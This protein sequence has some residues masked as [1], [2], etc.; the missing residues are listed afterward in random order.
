VEKR[1]AETIAKRLEASGITVDPKKIE[2]GI[3]T[4]VQR[5]V[6]L[7]HGYFYAMKGEVNAEL[8]LDESEMFDV[9]KITWNEMFEEPK[10]IEQIPLDNL[11]VSAPE[12]LIEPE[13]PAPPVYHSGYFA[14][15]VLSSQNHEISSAGSTGATGFAF[16][17]G[18]KDKEKN[19]FYYEHEWISDGEDNDLIFKGIHVDWSIDLGRP[20]Y[21]FFGVGYSIAYL[22]GSNY[23]YDGSAYH[24]RAGAG[25]ELRDNM[26]LDLT[27]RK[28]EVIW[29]IANGDTDIA[30]LGI[31]RNTLSYQLTWSY[32]F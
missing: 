3:Q 16:Q 17:L 20:I 23:T 8:V 4:R 25:Y 15:L 29:A 11:P 9:E 14:S 5:Y 21:P 26:E 30:D 12:A 6:N 27:I 7:D 28:S 31:S 22:K 13:E 18:F 1:S 24:L 32:L 10:E 19:R 2:T